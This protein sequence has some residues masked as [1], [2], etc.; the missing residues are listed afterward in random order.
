[1][2]DVHAPAV[3]ATGT[4]TRPTFLGVLHNPEFRAVWL[5]DAQS[6]LGDQL[7]R[8]AL[9]VLVYERSHSPFMTALIYAVTFI[10]ALFSGVLLGGLADRYPHRATLVRCNVLRAAL[11]GAMALAGLP[12]WALVGLVI[13]STLVAAPF[14]AANSA[15]LPDLLDGESYPVAASLRTIGH[16]VSQ[17]MGFAAG[18]LLLTAMSPRAALL[19]DAVTF[20]VAAAMVRRAVQ[21]RPAPLRKEDS[22]PYLASIV[23]GARTVASSPRLR[24]LLGLAWLMGLFVIPEGLA[25][26]YA[27]F[28]HA[29]T[30]GVGLLLAAG[31]AGTALGSFLFFKVFREPRRVRMIGVLAA[32]G[33][34]PLVVCIAAPPLVPS[35]VLW[36]LCGGCGAYL[37][38][39]MPEYVVAA[40]QARRG[41]AIGIAASGLLAVQGVGIL[42]GG[43]VADATNPAVAVA[44]AGGLASVLAAVLSLRWR[45]I[46]NHDG[47]TIRRATELSSN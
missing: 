38:Q 37:T 8:I 29:D 2:T 41:Q 30:L 3:P 10:P 5:A 40:P 22:E 35:L 24:V 47:E 46:L 31:P 7:S 28:I 11:V 26:P 39:V 45:Q 4:T 27:A 33:G 18:G 34:V 23:T 9:A 21:L 6:S 16:Q 36:G 32:A 42:L 17:L 20:L 15:M 25:A 43:I 19:I 14:D 13:L 12:I 44:V 1:M